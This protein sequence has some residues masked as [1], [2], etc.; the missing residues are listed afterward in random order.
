MIKR[1][2]RPAI[3]LWVSLV[4]YTGC[5]S[6][7]EPQPFDCTISTL[8]VEGTATSPSACGVS[9]G[10][11][12]AIA[13]G[14]DTPYQFALDAGVYS[15]SADFT[16][17]AAGT[18]TL[19]I[20]DLNDCERT[21]SITINP[22]GSSLAATVEVAN[23]GCKTNKGTITIEATGGTGPYT[24]QLN[25]GATSSE[26][27]S[28]LGAGEYSVKVTDDTGCAIVQTVKV[29]TGVSFITD[30]QS[31]ITTNCAVSGCHVSGGAAPITFTTF[32]N[33]QSR[34]SQIKSMTQSGSMPK[35]GSKLPQAQL[36]LIGCW[37]D[38]GALNN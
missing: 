23:S 29:A 1:I 12:T 30:I 5:T 6:S 31:I 9:D 34:A 35:D 27:Y 3:L 33:I 32:S 37:V 20:K 17:L 18:H 8:A 25:G 15:A 11:I 16:G 26:I 28:D 38:D 4:A 36:D 13:S 19:K 2:T 21:K 7:D 22:F 14:G 24:Y 10:V